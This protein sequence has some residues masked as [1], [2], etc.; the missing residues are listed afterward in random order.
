MY[1]TNFLA[2]SVFLPSLVMVQL[3]ISPNCAGLPA[4]PAIAVTM[5][6][7]LARYAGSA[8]H[9]AQ[10]G[11]ASLRR[12]AISSSRK[13]D[14]TTM[15]A[16]PEKYVARVVST[17][18][19]PGTEKFRTRSPYSWKVCTHW[20]ESRVTVLFASTSSQPLPRARFSKV[21]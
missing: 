18:C 11:S 4:G 2:D 8:L 7:F 12:P 15:A 17:S 21:C 14:Q 13:E 10:V 1:W 19:A 9:C 3:V 6:L 20:G 16:L 5:P